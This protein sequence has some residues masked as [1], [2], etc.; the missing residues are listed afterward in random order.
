MES[1]EGLWELLG[2]DL[3]LSWEAP[4][5]ALRGDWED[6]VSTIVWVAH[7]FEMLFAAC[8]LMF[9]ACRDESFDLR[10]NG[11]KSY[12][13]NHNCGCGGRNATGG[14][15]SARTPP[16]DREYAAAPAMICVYIMQKRRRE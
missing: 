15:V 6:P 3:L 1:R 5:V 13:E 12:F 16:P 7:P 8:F 11:T 10:L 2:G 9:L 14:E 4:W